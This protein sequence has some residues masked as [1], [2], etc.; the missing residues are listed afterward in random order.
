MAERVSPFGVGF[1]VDEHAALSDDSFHA[2]V[3]SAIER[4]QALADA[5][6]DRRFDV[7]FA[8]EV[9]RADPA[10]ASS[11]ADRPVV[12]GLARVSL[13]TFNLVVTDVDGRFPGHEPKRLC[14]ALDDALH[15]AGTLAD[16]HPG[17]RFGVYVRGKSL[18][19]EP[20]AAPSV[21][22]AEVRA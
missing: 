19:V 8:V 21:E 6:P 16:Q 12:T 3:M 2:D 7:Y 15:A 4:G 20:A 5:H 22:P 17:R 9:V 10:A 11:P 13:G 14:G 1:F 18:R